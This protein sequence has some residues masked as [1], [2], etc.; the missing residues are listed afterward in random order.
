LETI[1]I[2]RLQQ[3]APELARAF[4]AASPFPHLVL[5]DLLRIDPTTMAR[6]P[7][8]DWPHWVQLTNDYERQKTACADIEV[9]PEP[10]RDVIRDLSSPRFLRF[11]EAVTGIDR[12]LPDP[13]LEGGGLH[14]IGP[15][16]QLAPHTDFHLHEGLALYR[17]LNLLVYLNADWS[18]DDGGQVVLSHPDALHDGL[19]VEPTWGTAVLF[20]TDD[21]SVH[22]VRPVGPSARRRSIALYYY[23]ST[24][25][26]RF[27]G[28]QSTHW[29]IHGEGGWVYRLRVLLYQA[30][31]KGSRAFSM[32]AHLANPNFGLRMVRERLR[33]LR[34]GKH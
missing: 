3:R 27:A 33:A 32:A 31:M 1:E 16:G 8:S 22:G 34:D 11:L 25:T 21:D 29:R 20:E 4:R 17:R 24:E 14:C 2:E 18:P 6:F 9:I 30:L 26:R 28:D 5:H 12:L 19:E 10:F 15:G 7:A 13:H 23:T